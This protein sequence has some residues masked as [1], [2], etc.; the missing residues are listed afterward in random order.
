MI[1][2]F[3]PQCEIVVGTS[4]LMIFA[5]LLVFCLVKLLY[6]LTKTMLLDF[7]KYLILFKQMNF[8]VFCL[9]SWVDST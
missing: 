6:Y 3:D 1:L 2:Q 9:Y 8:Y 4:T 7:P 5:G